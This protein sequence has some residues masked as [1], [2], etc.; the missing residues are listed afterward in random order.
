M[1]YEREGQLIVHFPY[2]IILGSREPLLSIGLCQVHLELILHSL[3]YLETLL[4]PRIDLSEQRVVVGR[5]LVQHV[6]LDDHHLQLFHVKPGVH[7]YRAL[8]DHLY[9]TAL[10]SSVIFV[11]AFERIAGTCETAL[12][13]GTVCIL[14]FVILL[15]FLFIFFAVFVQNGFP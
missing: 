7:L 12:L 2:Y 15:V 11:L 13:E 9:D 14:I 3:E 10:F 4:V 1:V 8:V 5:V 6:I